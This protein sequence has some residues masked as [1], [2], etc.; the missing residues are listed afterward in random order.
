[1]RKSWNSRTATSRRWI[2]AFAS[3]S[4]ESIDITFVPRRLG[5][6]VNSLTKIA[7]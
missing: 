3:P 6:E 4:P 5:R 2:V 1:M 7:T